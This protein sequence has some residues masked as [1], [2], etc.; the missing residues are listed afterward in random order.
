MD[1]APV[2]NMVPLT[3]VILTKDEE[4]NIAQALQ[5]VIGW[6][7]DIFILDSGSIDRTCEIAKSFG[8]RV[9][10]RQ[11]D[12][13][14][15]QRNYAIQKLPIET[16]WMLFLDADEYLS[17]KL[18]FEIFEVLS[19]KET[20][21]DGYYIKY[22]FYFMGKWIKYGGYY[23]T[24]ILRLFR[25]SK[26]SISRE[27]NEHV[28]VEGFTENLKNDFI[29]NDLKGFSFWLNKHIYYAALEAKELMK[30]KKMNEFKN[31]VSF[32]NFWGSQAQR[33][34]WV[35]EHI[36]NKMMPPLVRPFI[37]FVYRYIFR[38]GFLD[39]RVGL[40]FH[41]LHGLFYPL[42]IDVKYL[43]LKRNDAKENP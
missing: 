25:R 43:E 40:V 10:Y 4:V 35:R 6:A 31:E 8:A 5:S 17:E 26:A 33:K 39:G 7:H 12:N 14:A 21:V 1:Q 9:F 27:M 19:K 32:A 36:W 34:R 2:L 29:H 28:Y 24:Y 38:L 37:Y 22:R 42:I 3:V 41:L 18:K 16:E 13:Y 11:F 23:P 20:S 15:N 30:S